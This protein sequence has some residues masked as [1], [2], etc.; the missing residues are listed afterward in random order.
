[1]TI[2]ALIEEFDNKYFMQKEENMFCKDVIYEDRASCGTEQ[3]LPEVQGRI[4]GAAD[5]Q[6]TQGS[7]TP[8]ASKSVGRRRAS[9]G[10][11]ACK[12]RW[13]KAEPPADADRAGL[14]VIEIRH[15]YIKGTDAHHA[16]V[17]RALKRE[18]YHPFKP[19]SVHELNEDD[20][21][22]RMELCEFVVV[23]RGGSTQWP[24]RS[25]HLAACEYWLW[26]YLKEKVYAWRPQDVDMLK[27]A[28]EEEI[29]AIPMDI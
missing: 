22:K 16:S 15:Y 2:S 9:Y 7:C 4:S 11:P 18:K 21:D 1:M 5:V 26:D 10:Q 8:L 17:I 24:A 14:K 25:P 3:I 20:S 23:G 12:G 19:I 27:I 29:H 28:I 6:R 13:N